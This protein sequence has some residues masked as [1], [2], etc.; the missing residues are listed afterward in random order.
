[1]AEKK[2]RVKHKTLKEKSKE[3]ERKEKQKGRK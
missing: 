1:L 2:W 3:K